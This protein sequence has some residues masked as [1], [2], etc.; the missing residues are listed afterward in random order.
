MSE[1][2]KHTPSEDELISAGAV[3]ANAI[4]FSGMEGGVPTV[5]LSLAALQQAIALDRRGVR[6]VAQERCANAVFAIAAELASTSGLDPDQAA[7]AL[8]CS[9][10]VGRAAKAILALD[11]SRAALQKAESSK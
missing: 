2:A 7:E 11:L 6:V 3:I 9:A 1:V 5:T 8:A 4:S 10:E